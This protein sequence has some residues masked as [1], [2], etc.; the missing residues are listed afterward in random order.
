[1]YSQF[2][3]FNFNDHR[4]SIDA[5]LKS[6]SQVVIDLVSVA[7]Y[8]VGYTFFLRRIALLAAGDGLLSVRLPAG[9]I[10]SILLILSKMNHVNDTCGNCLPTQNSEDP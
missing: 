10:L 5:F 1:M 3:S 7:D 2:G 4:F 8:F 6:K 9:N